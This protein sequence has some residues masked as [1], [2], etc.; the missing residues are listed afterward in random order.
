MDV[1]C[2]VDVVLGTAVVSVRQC[3]EFQLQSIVRL[4][5]LAG[6]DLEMRV[7]GIPLASGEVVIAEESVGLRITK[8][9]PPVGLESL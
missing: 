5:E 2:Q 9:L 1:P 6:A 7:G 3:A 8:V 4:K